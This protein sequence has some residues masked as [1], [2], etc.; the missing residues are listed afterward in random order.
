[1]FAGSSGVIRTW[2]LSKMAICRKQ[3]SGGVPKWPPGG[4]TNGS[5]RIDH[6]NYPY[7]VRGTGPYY[8]VQFSYKSRPTDVISSY[9]AGHLSQETHQLNTIS[10]ESGGTLINY[11]LNYDRSRRSANADHCAGMLG[12]DVLTTYDHRISIRLRWWSSAARRP[13]P[14]VQLVNGTV[15]RPQ[16]RWKIGRP[17]YHP[18]RNLGGV[19][20]THRIRSPSRC[21]WG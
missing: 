17:L 14:R 5:F 9:L 18:E 16:R 7:L 13:F 12:N 15:R 4:P 10:V 8:K 19:I 21:G 1:M 6:I 2:A 3:H 20:D 11:A